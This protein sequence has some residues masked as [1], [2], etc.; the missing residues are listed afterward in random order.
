MPPTD[1][2]PTAIDLFSGAG[3][4]TLGLKKAGFRVL[5]AVER[6]EDVSKT[7]KRNHPHVKLLTKDT[8]EV[9]AKELLDSAGVKSVDLV[10]GCPPCQGFSKLTDKYKRDDDRNELVGVMARL[11]VALK[12]RVVMMENVPGLAIRGKELF[13]H[14]LD[15]LT[16]AGYQME[17]QVLQLA[18]YGVPQSRRRL[19]VLGGLGFKVSMPIPT[20]SRKGDKKAGLRPWRTLRDAIDGMDK[21]VTLSKACRNGGPEAFAWHVVGDLTE[22]TLDRLRALKA[23]TS[24]EGLPKR[25]RPKCHK[26]KN[27]GFENVYGRMSWDK[28]AP[29]ITGGCTTPCKGRYGHPR[30]LRTISVREAALIQTFPMS[31]KFVTDEMGTACAMVGNALPPKFAEIAARQCLPSAT[32]VGGS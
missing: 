1:P 15:T 12:P 7:F 29:T 10:A 6:D 32:F 4:L 14:F 19:V 16:A 3:G 25:L 23:G 20:H 17:W 28:A 8:R 11:V 22:V 27:A 31:Y 21:P 18:N 24:R 26:K 5:G 30:Q 13:D 2:R 9:T